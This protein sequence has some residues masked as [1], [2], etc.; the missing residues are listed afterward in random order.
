MYVQAIIFRVRASCA[1]LKRIVNT[2]QSEISAERLNVAG[3]CARCAGK[4]PSAEF[5]RRWEALKQKSEAQ[6]YLG[7]VE[8]IDSIIQNK[9]IE[10]KQWREVALGITAN[11][12]GERVQSSGRPSKMSD[13][14]EKCVDIEREIDGYIDKLIDVKLEIVQTLEQLDNPFEYRI[15]H[16]KYIQFKT[17]EEIAELTGK[18]YTAIT[19]AHG[20]ALVQVQR[21]LEARNEKEGRA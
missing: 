9:L 12:D 1:R 21:I 6:V 15:L 3:M 13:A 20:R 16:Y 18:S 14:V 8:L 2:I 4:R 5:T 10:R 7:Q 11:M 19:T 17:L